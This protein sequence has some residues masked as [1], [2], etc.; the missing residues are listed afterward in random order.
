M[1]Y[2]LDQQFD[3]FRYYFGSFDIKKPL[4]NPLRKDTTP[5]CYF[6][7]KN[8]KLIFIDWAFIPT[9][10]DCIEYVKR[11]Y[12]LGDRL[13]SIN[14]INRDL[15]YTDKTKGNFSNNVIEESKQTPLI[16]YKKNIITED[17]PIYSVIDKSL[18]DFEI[19]YWL[20]F[21]ISINTLNK[22]EIKPVKYVLKDKVINYSAS[23]YNPIFGYY[24]NN[25]L[26]KIY[27][28]LGSRFFKWRT[29]KALLEGYSKL[30]YNTNVC[31]ITSSLKDTMCL[32]ELG[33]DAFNLP[34]ENS[35]KILLPI[36]EKLFQKFEYIYVYLNNDNTGK[37]YSK[38]LTLEID[39]R[40]QYINNPSFLKETDPSDI[41]KNLGKDYLLEIID[42]K[43]NRDQIKLV[44]INGK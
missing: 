34:S 30:E 17:K 10:L 36:I 39:Q 44:Q 25:E 7:I 20:K 5:K 21:N 16:T 43:L 41:I 33:F 12:N 11:L 14:K 15:K 19:D 27:N 8:D 26:F 35:Y 22:Y 31:F 2:T 32:Y 6:N 28:P 29:I 3:V 9:H 40:L 37:E 18:E 4:K 13:Q 23:R 1:I 24:E 38:L 42:E